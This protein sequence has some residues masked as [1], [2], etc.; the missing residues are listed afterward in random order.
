MGDFGQFTIMP[1]TGLCLATA[2]RRSS[3]YDRPNLVVK[4]HYCR[5]YLVRYDCLVELV[6][7]ERCAIFR[8]S[9]Y[10][11]GTARLIFDIFSQGEIEFDA[12]RREAVGIARANHGG[13][14]GDFGCRF[15]A[16]LNRSWTNHTPPSADATGCME[17]PVEKGCTVELRIATSWVSTD[18][19]RLTLMD[20]LKER[21]F[22][23][24]R[25]EA[26]EAWEQRLGKVELETD[27][28]EIKKTFYSCLYRTFLF[29]QKMHEKGP[30]GG[31]IHYSPYTG[32]V[33]DG[34]LY[35]NNG[36]W[37]THRTVYPLFSL[38]CPKDYSEI[39]QGWLQA[40]RGKRMVSALAKSRLA[41]LHDRH[42]YR[43]SFPG[44][45]GEGNR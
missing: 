34:R 16:L 44:C 1:Q 29:P 7:T 14:M 33:H 30:D 8:F 19:A 9:F 31:L 4:P 15:V 37:D 41:R 39:L 11:T 24:I 17:F 40:Q 27:D 23:E 13:V 20:E 2:A 5:V 6:P 22:E 10:N 21:S 38:L 18:Q 12:A 36:F 26:Q 3:T 35:T 42:P 25:G 32:K 43:R 28:Q 45:G